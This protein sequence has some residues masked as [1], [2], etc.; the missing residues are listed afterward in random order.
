[1]ANRYMSTPI[2]AHFISIETLVRQYIEKEGL[3]QPNQQVHIQIDLINVPS[4]VIGTVNQSVDELLAM[5]IDDFCR[6]TKLSNR[7]ANILNNV[8]LMTI[9]QLVRQDRNYILK[10]RN[11]GPKTVNEIEAKIRQIGLPFGFGYDHPA[12]P[13]EK[14]IHLDLPV[15]YCPGS[16]LFPSEI[17]CIGDLMNR[18]CDEIKAWIPLNHRDHIMRSLAEYLRQLGLNLRKE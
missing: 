9:G 1:M 13:K 11:C 16:S 4:V 5:S 6:V 12:G 7:S 8:C 14:K 15:M 17:K 3:L 18:T 10:Q 2:Q